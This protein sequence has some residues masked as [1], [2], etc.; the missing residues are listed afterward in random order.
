M[1]VARFSTSETDIKPGNLGCKPAGGDSPSLSPTPAM[2]LDLA[3]AGSH[4]SQ[5]FLFP[6]G[7]AR[8]KV[9]GTFIVARLDRMAQHDKETA[10]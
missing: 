3:K 6:V 2:A 8:M 5:P 9:L 4:W 10:M 7:S 1:S